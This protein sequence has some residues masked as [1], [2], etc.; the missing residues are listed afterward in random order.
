M[1]APSRERELKRADKVRKDYLYAVAPSR[2]REL[3]PLAR[4]QGIDISE[5]L[6][7]GS[8]N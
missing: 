6:P 3:K 2:E 5:S 1:V 8:V 4:K 7:H